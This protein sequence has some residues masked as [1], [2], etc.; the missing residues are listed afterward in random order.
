M[1]HLNDQQQSCKTT[2]MFATRLRAT[3]H[4]SGKPIDFAYRPTVLRQLEIGV[5]VPAWGSFSGL[6]SPF[7]RLSRSTGNSAG[8]RCRDSTAASWWS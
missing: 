8:P 7:E 2:P 4:K 1:F 3:L 5:S 6:S